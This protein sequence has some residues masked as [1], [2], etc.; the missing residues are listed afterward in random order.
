MDQKKRLTLKDF[1]EQTWPESTSPGF[2]RFLF[3]LLTGT[4]YRRKISEWVI[5]I[6]V[7]GCIP[8]FFVLGKY[9]SQEMS[10]KVFIK[11]LLWGIILG[12]TIGAA[13]M[14]LQTGLSVKRHKQLQ[15][16]LRTQN[17]KILKADVI[18]SLEDTNNAASIFIRSY[19]NAAGAF[20]SAIQIALDRCFDIVPIAHTTI[21]P[22]LFMML[23]KEL[24]NTKPILDMEEKICNIWESNIHEAIFGDFSDRSAF[25]VTRRFSQYIYELCTRT[26]DK[27]K[28]DPKEYGSIIVEPRPDAPVF[29]WVKYSYNQIYKELG[30]RRAWPTRKMLKEYDSLINKMDEEAWQTIKKYNSTSEESWPV[31]KTTRDD[32][33]VEPETEVDVTATKDNQSAIFNIQNF[34]GI[35]GDVQAENV[36]TG[37]IPISIS[38]SKLL[39]KKKSIFR[40]LLTIIIAVVTFLAALLTVLHYLG[41][42]EPIKV[43]GPE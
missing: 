27:A 25:D 39:D 29:N 9:V 16:F 15:I 31:T 22:W 41:W 32:I 8:L 35:F 24:S 12:Y 6:V 28:I 2:F 20:T 14:C 30:G 1:Q 21:F 26:R 7:L 33:Q 5:F 37:I 19:F 23:E 18:K 10:L 13:V 38:T 11:M 34:M 43:I 40:G 3:H 36:H 17:T 4:W 42:L